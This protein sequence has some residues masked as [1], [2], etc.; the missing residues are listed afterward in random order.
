MRTVGEEHPP[1][2]R[3]EVFVVRWGSSYRSSTFGFRG[4]DFYYRVTR[5]MARNQTHSFL[6]FPLFLTV[7]QR[8]RGECLHLRSEV[9]IK[10][11]VKIS[12]C[13]Y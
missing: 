3:G 2:A 7:S 4:S 13:L 5:Q 8:E 11:N 6:Y 1:L 9:E 10:L 12:E